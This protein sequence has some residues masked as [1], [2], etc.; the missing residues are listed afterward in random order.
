VVLRDS[1]YNVTEYDIPIAWNDFKKLLTGP[2]SL[3]YSAKFIAECA[4]KLK[5]IRT[6][7]QANV[8]KFYRPEDTGNSHFW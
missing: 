5:K 3:V 4:E 6:D 7:P 1:K 2:R 8:N